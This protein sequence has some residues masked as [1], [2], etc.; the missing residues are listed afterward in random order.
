MPTLTAT[1]ARE[2]LFPLLDHVNTDHDIVRIT[3]KGGTCVLMSETDY[4]AWQTTLYLM[5]NPAN[6]AHLRESLSQA[7]AGQIH[8]VDPTLLDGEDDQ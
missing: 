1:R 8:E 2:R 7:R 4:D 5:S 3:A 6:A